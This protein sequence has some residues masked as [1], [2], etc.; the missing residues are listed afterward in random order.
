MT[1][2]IKRGNLGSSPSWFSRDELDLLGVALKKKDKKKEGG[3]VDT[4]LCTQGEHHINIKA[5]ISVIRIEAKEY[6]RLPATTRSQ[7]RD[8]KHTFFHSSLNKSVLQMF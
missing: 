1:V 6:R 3:N 5:E 4:D 8:M 2:L 7:G